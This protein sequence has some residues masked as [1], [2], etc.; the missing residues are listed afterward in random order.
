MTRSILSISILLSCAM[1]FAQS[2]FSVSTD[3]PDALY[4]CG[5]EAVF[6]VTALNKENQPI[7]E[8]TVTAILDGFGGKRLATQ[9]IDLAAQNPFQIKGTLAKP[10]FLRLRVNGDRFKETVWGVGYEPQ[11]IRPGG[12]CPDDFDAFWA[13]AIKNAEETVPLDPKVTPVPEKSNGAFT[14][15]RV[16]F[17][18]LNDRRVHGYMT[19]PKDQAKA[20]FPVQVTV[21]GAGCGNWANQVNGSP[22]RI[23]LFMSVMLF[24]PDYDQNKVQPLYNE[25]VKSLEARYQTIGY[26]SSGIA[27]SREAYFYYPVILGINRAVNW[28]AA[29]P[30]VDLKRFNYSGTSQGGGFGLILCGLNKHFTKGAI[31]VPAI[32]DFFGYKKDRQSGWPRII[33]NQAENNRPAAEK[34]A[35]YF[36]GVNFAA[37]ITI[38]VRVVVG[39]AD[40]TCAP[41]AVY[42]G[43][44]TI[45][46][47]DKQILH[48][49]GMGHGVRGEFYRQLGDWL[50]KD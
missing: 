5:E 38:P 4:T 13:N 7:R 18:T 49:I 20:P 28:V 19:V 17:A 23:V 27:E 12:S 32:T 3:H 40:M 21:P 39:F 44:N 42:A 41:C 31:F 22:N 29:R 10:G 50:S 24:E 11:K 34:N 25:M 2:H 47:K 15:Y 36:D 35:P 14:F 8:G 48:G 30:D 9:S 16:S 33:E 1:A 45:P 37:R 46:A 6:T 26:P 43:Y